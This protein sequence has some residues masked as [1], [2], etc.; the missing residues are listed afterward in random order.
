M[1]AKKKQKKPWQMRKA[2]TLGGKAL[3][4]PVAERNRVLRELL[5]Q[6]GYKLNRKKKSK[7]RI[8]DVEGKKGDRTA[9]LTKKRK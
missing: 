5:E 8:A 4:L 3:K 9:T 6:E 1:P 7:T 2:T